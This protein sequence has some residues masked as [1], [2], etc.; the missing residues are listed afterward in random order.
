MKTLELIKKYFSDLG[1][2]PIREVNSRSLS[3]IYTAIDSYAGTTNFKNEYIAALFSERLGGFYIN[4]WELP[5][6]E[7]ELR[8]ELRKTI[9]M[10]YKKSG[11]E[12]SIDFY[13]E[14]FSKEIISNF[15]D[16]YLFSYLER[17]N[18]PAVLKWYF[19]SEKERKEL[20]RQTIYHYALDLAYRQELFKKLSTEFAKVVKEEMEKNTI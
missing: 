2:T 12:G 17:T 13:F 7:E 19:I 9:I 10:Y 14:N 3:S 15:R 20:I 4:N 8:N 6:E 5:L 16:T 18:S 1:I 11:P